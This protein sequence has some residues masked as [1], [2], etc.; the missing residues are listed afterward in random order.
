MLNK[1]VVMGRL[2]DNPELRETAT[3]VKVCTFSVAV[4]RDYKVNREQKT[5][6]FNI[7]HVLA[8][9]HN[10]RVLLVDMDK[11]GNSTKFFGKHSYGAQSVSDVLT[12]STDIDITIQRTA[13][14]RLDIIPANMSLLRTNSSLLIDTSRS[15]GPTLSKSEAGRG[16]A[17][18]L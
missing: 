3:G 6:F 5:D 9:V 14:E 11:Q 17:I 8:A 16:Q 15:R 2:T 1:T 13:F 12:W 7:V 18:S 4:E 10:R